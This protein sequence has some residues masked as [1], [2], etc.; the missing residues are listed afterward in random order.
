MLLRGRHAQPTSAVLL[1][2]GPDPAGRA[3]RPQGPGEAPEPAGARAAG[4]AQEAPA[5]GRRPHAPAP[6]RPG[7]GA[8]GGQVPPAAGGPV[9]VPPACTPVGSVHTCDRDG[10]CTFGGFHWGGHGGIAKGCSLTPSKSRFGARKIEE[11]F[12][13]GSHPLCQGARPL[14]KSPTRSVYVQRLLPLQAPSVCT[15]RMGLVVG[16]LDP[17]PTPP[18][19]GVLRCLLGS[20]LSATALP[21]Q[22]HVTTGGSPRGAL[23]TEAGKT[24]RRRRKR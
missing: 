18:G 23:P 11:S 15:E 14:L 3:P 12:H 4:A 10:V 19:A 20:A 13:T 2:G 17:A 5:E 16:I 8:G 9:S 24:R 1:R 21:A 6:R 7:S 22:V